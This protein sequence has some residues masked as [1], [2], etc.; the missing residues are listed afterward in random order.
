MQIVMVCRFYENAIGFCCTRGGSH[1]LNLGE[2]QLKSNLVATIVAV[3]QLWEAKESI[4]QLSYVEL[5]VG[6]TSFV[7]IAGLRS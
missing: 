6:K 2:A 3:Q 7:T 4:S 1:E 5:F